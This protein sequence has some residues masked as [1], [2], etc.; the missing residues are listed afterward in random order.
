MPL[1]I[2]GIDQNRKG[3]L[4]ALYLLRFLDLIGYSNHGGHRKIRTHFTNVPHA[5]QFDPAPGEAELLRMQ[6]IMEPVAAGIPVWKQLGCFSNM[7]SG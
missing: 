7:G 4:K 1:A 3:N 5:C 6:R 2:E